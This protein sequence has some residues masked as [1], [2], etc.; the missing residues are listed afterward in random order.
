MNKS[1]R[2]FYRFKRGYDL[3]DFYNSRDYVKKRCHKRLRKQLLKL[4]H[5][6][7]QEK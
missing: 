2:K 3:E 7:L 1:V 6:E 5:K 4:L